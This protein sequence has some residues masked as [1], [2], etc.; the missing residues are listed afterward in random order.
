[1]ARRL[2]WVRKALVR[3]VRSNQARYRAAEEVFAAEDDDAAP[4]SWRGPRPRVRLGRARARPRPALVRRMLLGQ[5]AWLDGQP[6]WQG[7]RV[8]WSGAAGSVPLTAAGLALAERRL[9]QLAVLEAGIA[10]AAADEAPLAR[11]RRH[12]TC[13]GA[14]G[15]NAFSTVANA[16]EINKRVVYATAGDGRIVGRQLIAITEDWGLVGF[17]IYTNRPDGPTDDALRGLFRRYAGAVAAAC[18]LPLA[19]SGRAPLLFAQEWYDDGIWGWAAPPDAGAST[20]GRRG[21]PGAVPGRRGIRG[22]GRA[23]RPRRAG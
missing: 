23:R 7:G 13:L 1:M 19:D 4:A 3:R 10:H 20:P 12:L 11:R 14:D 15:V 2:R 8:A 21:V 17:R 5:T 18:G 6:I 9:R 16:C 22:R